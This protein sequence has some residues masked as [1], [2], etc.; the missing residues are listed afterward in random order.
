MH[1]FQQWQAIYNEWERET[2]DRGRKEGLREGIQ[3]GEARALLL[4]LEE[5]FGELPAA[6]TARVARANMNQIESWLGR[7]LHA[8]TLEDV[9]TR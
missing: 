4:M 3:A 9:F 8:A 2:S 7:V 1:L 6:V 5:R